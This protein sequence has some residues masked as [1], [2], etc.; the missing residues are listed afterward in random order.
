M[1]LFK[2]R[3]YRAAQ[4]WQRFDKAVYQEILAALQ[5]LTVSPLLNKVLIMPDGDVE[6]MRGMFARVV[7]RAV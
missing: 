6:V 7:F 5:S 4:Q 3:C 2:H 1:G